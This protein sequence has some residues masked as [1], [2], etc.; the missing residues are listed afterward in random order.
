MLAEL[1]DRSDAAYIDVVGRAIVCADSERR[2]SFEEAF[3][4]FPEALSR[5]PHFASG[6]LAAAGCAHFPRSGDPVVFERLEPRDRILLVGTIG[7]PA[8]PYVWAEAAAERSGA[9]LLTFLGEGHGAYAPDRPCVRNAVEEV[10]LTGD[11]R[12]LEATECP[13]DFPGFGGNFLAASNRTSRAVPTAS[14]PTFPS[15]AGR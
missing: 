13:D 15:I 9:P 7:D 11:A 3:A 1:R 2:V 12:S 14:W 4:R 8:T 6:V 5:A 10:L